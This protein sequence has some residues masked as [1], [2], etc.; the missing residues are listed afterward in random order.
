ML[1]KPKRHT[2]NK[3]EWN[4]LTDFGYFCPL[5]FLNHSLAQIEK[6]L[7]VARDTL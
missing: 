6:T 4:N 5:F 2:S 7:D 3:K 1:I